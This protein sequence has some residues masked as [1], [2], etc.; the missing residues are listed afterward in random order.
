M[1]KIYQ[2]IHKFCDVI[3]YFNTRRWYFTNTNVMVS[4]A[5]ITCYLPKSKSNIS[6]KF[7]TLW[8]KLDTKDK[9]MFYFDMKDLDW[10]NF[11]RESMF[12]MRQYLMKDDPSTI[13]DAIKRMKK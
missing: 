1:V 8:K 2:K 5:L 11:T 13:P 4:S 6:N 3:S 7:Q 9:Q 10:D 12:G